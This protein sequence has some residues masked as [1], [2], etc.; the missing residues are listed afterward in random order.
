MQQSYLPPNTT[1]STMPTDADE[2]LTWIRS[3]KQMRDCI[4]TGVVND[5][6]FS[7]LTVSAFYKK[8]LDIDLSTLPQPIAITHSVTTAY[9]NYNRERLLEFQENRHNKKSL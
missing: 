9:W 3:I 2:L 7:K 5:N 1:I 8:L 6:R 4:T